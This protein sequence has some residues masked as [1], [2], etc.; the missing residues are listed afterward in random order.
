MRCFSAYGSE[1]RQAVSRR[2][3]R[4]RN[5]ATNTDA[6]L[7]P[8]PHAE[9]RSTAAAGRGHEPVTSSVSVT[10]GWGHGLRW[11]LYALLTALVLVGLLELAA[12]PST[13]SSPRILHQRGCWVWSSRWGFP[14][15]QACPDRAAP[16]WSRWSAPPDERPGPGRR[17]LV[18]SGA[19][20]VASGG[21]GIPEPP[22][23]RGG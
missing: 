19:R 16:A 22:G 7:P 5:C 11:G 20:R 14:V 8:H 15:A 21:R 3:R 23:S 6:D 12:V 18:A 10:S 17:G 13:R 1:S 9:N 2:Y 4:P